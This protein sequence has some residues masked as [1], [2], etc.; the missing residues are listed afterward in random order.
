MKRPAQSGPLNS[1]HAQLVRPDTR[2][3]IVIKP[4]HEDQA[5]RNDCHQ[6]I[7]DAVFLNRDRSGIGIRAQ[8]GQ[9]KRNDQPTNQRA[10]TQPYRPNQDPPQ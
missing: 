4:S 6:K 7:D 8:S 2:I 5:Q 1:H 10:R 9:N 3:Q